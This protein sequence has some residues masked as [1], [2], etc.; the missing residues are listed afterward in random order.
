MQT[1]KYADDTIYTAVSADALV[2]NATAHKATVTH[3]NTLQKAADYYASQWCN[4]NFMLLQCFE[5]HSYE[6]NTE[7]DFH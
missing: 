1:V 7:V 5:V 3:G 2:S 4:D 6:L